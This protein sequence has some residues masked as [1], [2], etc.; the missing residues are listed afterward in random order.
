MNNWSVT[1]KEIKYLRELA[2]KQLEYSMLPIMKERE[3]RWYR[4][5]D[6]K[7]EIPMIHFETGTC[8]HDLLPESKCTSEAAKNIELSLNREVL[9]HELVDD[10]RVVP[11]WFNIRWHINF[12]IF[13]VDIKSTHAKDSEGRDLG[14]QFIHPI[15]DLQEDLKILKP[16][17]YSVDREGTLEWKA[18]V[19]DIIG[20]ILPVKMG[21]G[22]P[23]VCLSNRIVHLM[24]MEMMIYSLLDYPDEF[25]EIMGRLTNDYIAYLK[26]MENEGLLF[27]NNGNNNLTQGTFGF[28]NDL[29]GKD[30]K[31]ENGVKTANLWGYLDS[32]ET[33]SISPDMFDEFFFPY[34]HEAAKQFGLISYGCCEPVHSIWEKSLSKLTNLRKISISPWCDEDY[35][36]QVL[37]GRD[38]IY[39]RKPSPN[40]IGVVKEFDEEAF[41][42]HILKT[43]NSARGCKLEFSFRDVYTI[44]GN[45][46]K[47]RR[48]VQIVREL[49]EE[50]WKG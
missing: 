10:D 46:G 35:M 30:Y 6:L 50:N 9:N 44:N 5:N 14:Y 8:E 2:K 28:T 37:K 11:P 39:H 34:Y 42:Q 13:D 15:K 20:D 29:P 7:G 32:Q 41:R 40:Y 22:S 4:H 43:I 47:I 49:L 19:E 48:A 24:G 16:S 12:K 1:D 45:P 26:W 31:P 18:F 23:G 21:N 3:A 38:I 25:H 27:L 33:V 17:V 36:G